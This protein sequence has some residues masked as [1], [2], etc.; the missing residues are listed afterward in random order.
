MIDLLREFDLGENFISWIKVL[1]NNQKC[2]V[3]NGGI[4][5]KNLAFLMEVLLLHILNKNLEL[6]S[7]PIPLY[8]FILALEVH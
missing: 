1:L 2:R 7:D 6:E 8:I 5:M 3:F 4:L